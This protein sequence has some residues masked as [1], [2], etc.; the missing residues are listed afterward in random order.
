MNNNLSSTIAMGTFAQ[1]IEVDL[2]GS[3][4]QTPV[5][6]I[7]G[8]RDTNK[9]VKDR[10]SA[11]NT[12][13]TDELPPVVQF[14]KTDYTYGTDPMLDQKLQNEYANALGR[15]VFTFEEWLSKLYA[16]NIIKKHM[17]DMNSGNVTYQNGKIEIESSVPT[18]D[19]LKN[20]SA[21]DSFSVSPEQA[22]TTEEVVD[23]V[24]T[25]ST[26][27]TE[28]ADENISSDQGMEKLEEF[29]NS[30]TLPQK[31][32]LK[33]VGISNLADLEKESKRD[34]YKSIDDFIDQLKQ[35]F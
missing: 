8:N 22:D 17:K 29:Y 28:N 13:I 19:D 34:L 1:Y 25:I 21:E 32:K 23:D 14:E 2:M 6:F 10:V 12:N 18:A 24:F 4:A 26:D 33:D 3:T 20:A 30:L 5:G 7:F 31:L 16:Q 27:S 11:A 35:C 15:D 9:K